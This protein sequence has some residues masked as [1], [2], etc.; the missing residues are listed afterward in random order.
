MRGM[1]RAVR[2]T[3]GAAMA[4]WAIGILDVLAPHAKPVATAALEEISGDGRRAELRAQRMRLV[5]LYSLALAIASTLW[6][7]AH[8]A[9]LIV[10]ANRQWLRFA[11][12][13]VQAA[14]L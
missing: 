9:L 1:Q 2:T 11:I 5:A 13:V 10:A 12:T 8:C 6:V 3:V 7:A 14:I 4:S